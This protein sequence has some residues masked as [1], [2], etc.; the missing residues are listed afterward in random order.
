MLIFYFCSTHGQNVINRK[1]DKSTFQNLFALHQSTT[2]ANKLDSCQSDRRFRII[3]WCARLCGNHGSRVSDSPTQK[4]SDGH[5]YEQNPQAY[6]F[7]TFVK[8]RN[9]NGRQ[10]CSSYQCTLRLPI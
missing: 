4:S 1:C 9:R 2:R 6:I 3:L 5:C 10:D 7:L 8:K